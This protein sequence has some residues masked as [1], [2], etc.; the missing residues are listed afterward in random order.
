MTL[1]SLFLKFGLKGDLITKLEKVEK[2]VDS[3]KSSMLGLSIIVGTATAVIGKFVYEAAKI[4]Q[5]EIA[6]EVMTGSAKK[7][8]KMLDEM[9]QLARYTP[10]KIPGVIEASRTLMSMGIEAEKMKPTLTKIGDV[11]SGLNVPLMQLALTFGK[12]KAA[13]YLTGFELQNL[14]RAG[15]PLMQELEKITGKARGDIMTMIRKQ[16]ISFQ[17]FEQAWDN[18]TMKGG[19]FNNM[20]IRQS[21]TFLGIISNISDFIQILTIE[22]GEKLLPI[23]KKVANQFLIVLE[24]HKEV[25]KTKLGYFFADLSRILEYVNKGLLTIFFRTIDITTRL[26]GLDKI[27]KGILIIMSGFVT[28]KTFVLLGN[29]AKRSIKFFS[30]AQLKL[31]LLGAALLSVF[32]IF[33]DFIGFL[34]GK[35]S[36]IGRIIDKF[37]VKF[38]EAF[39]KISASMKAL[40]TEIEGITLYWLGFLKKDPKMMSFALSQLSDAYNQFLEEGKRRERANFGKPLR[41]GMGGLITNPLRLTSA[42]IKEVP[43]FLRDFL[44]GAEYADLQRKQYMPFKGYAEPTR[45]LVEKNIVN[46]IN[47]PLNFK[48]D[49]LSE[50]INRINKMV[51]KFKTHIYKSW[52]ELLRENYAFVESKQE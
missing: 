41:H 25:I 51:E 18:L 4:E 14:R 11:A 45:G 19:R 44:H 10:F 40:K 38:P 15:V 28:L 30:L 32:L 3:V 1:R 17:I 24:M 23:A 6:F 22:A 50:D 31:A 36:V 47:I 48:Y 43:D 13:G 35:D 21:A 42:A 16:E 49:P 2:K 26:G 20:M 7:G 9:F 39:N 52:D 5:V 46:N 33:E 8:K 12:V 27:L 37:A 29:L 34:E